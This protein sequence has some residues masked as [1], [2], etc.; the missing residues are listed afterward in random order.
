MSQRMEETLMF[1][2]AIVR[3]LNQSAAVFRETIDDGDPQGIGLERLA[4]R[5]EAYED[6]ALF[7]KGQARRVEGASRAARLEIVS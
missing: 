3:A 4:G 5:V 6:A 1:A 7:V 2:D